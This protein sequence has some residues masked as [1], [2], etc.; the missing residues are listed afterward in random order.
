MIASLIMCI[1]SWDTLEVRP[2]ERGIDTRQ[3]LLKFYSENY[4]ANLMH[5]VIYS[6]GMDNYLQIHYW[7]PKLTTAKSV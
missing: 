3:E 5:L 1:G 4:S 6:K 2:K 7:W